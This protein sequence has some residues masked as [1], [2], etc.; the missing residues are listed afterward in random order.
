MEARLNGQQEL[1]RTGVGVAFDASNMTFSQASALAAQLQGLYDQ[2][3]TYEVDE[4]GRNIFDYLLTDDMI[5]MLRD[6]TNQQWD[7]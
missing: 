6:K 5:A 4:Q 2:L 3:N 1:L 7:Y